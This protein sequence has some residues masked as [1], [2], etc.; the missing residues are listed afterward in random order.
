MNLFNEIASC[1]TA[2][3][4]RIV[5]K[6]TIYDMLLTAVEN[7]YTHSGADYTRYRTQNRE[8]RDTNE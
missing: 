3:Q 2:G 4:A 7:G 5:I 1:L 8:R 6:D